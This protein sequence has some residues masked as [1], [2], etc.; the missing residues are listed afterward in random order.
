ML[1]TVMR[2]FTRGIHDPDV[3]RDTLRGLVPADRSLFEVYMVAEESRRSKAEYALLQEEDARAQEFQFYKDVVHRNMPSVQIDSLKASFQANS[4]HWGYQNQSHPQ[5]QPM[6][7]PMAWPTQ[8]PAYPAPAP[9][10]APYYPPQP[11]QHP[12]PT[13]PN[14]YQAPRQAGR[15]GGNHNAGGGN[16]NGGGGNGRS[17]NPY[18]NGTRTFTPGSGVFV[19]IRCGEDGHISRNCINLPLSRNEQHTLR[20]MILGNRDQYPGFPRPAITGTGPLMPATTND[21]LPSRPPTVGVHSMT[22]GMAGLQATSRN[23][24]STEAFLGEGSGPNKRPHVE[25]AIPPIVPLASRPP[26]PPATFQPGTSTN[27]GFFFPGIPVQKENE[28]P[29]KKGQKRTGKAAT[30]APLVGLIDE[31]TG[32]VDKPTSVRQLLKSQKIDMTWMDFCVWSPTVCRELKRL[33]TRMSNRKKKVLGRS[34]VQADQG[35]DMNVISTAMARQLGLTFHSLS[36]VGFAGLTMKTADHRET[37]L[38]HWVYLEL[39]V[40]AIWRQIRCFVAPELQFPVQGLDHLSLLLGIPWL[41]SV[42]AII[43]IRGSKIEI[44]DPLQGEAVREVVGPE[45]VFSQDHNLLMYPKA[46]LT[47]TMDDNSD[48]EDDEVESDTDSSFRWAPHKEWWLRKL[49]QDGMLGG[50]YERTQHAN[51]RLSAWN[52]RAV[53]V[54]KEED[55][56]PTDEPRITFDCSKVKEDMPGSY[57]ELMSK[58]HDYL[59][60]PRHQTFFQADVKHGYFSVVLHPEDLHLFAF[61]IPGIG[62]LQPTQMPQ[63][64]RSAGF[65]MLELMNITLGPIPEPQSEPSLMHGEHAKPAPIAFYMDD[66][67]SGHPDF[68]SQFAFLRDQFFPRI[69]WAKLTLSFRKF[70]LFVDHIKALGVEHHVGGKVHILSKRV[71]TITKWPEPTNAKGLSFDILR[72]KY[73]TNVAMNGIDWSLDVYFYSDASGFAGGLV[74][75]QFQK[76]NGELNPVEVPIIYDALT[77]SVTEQK[78]QTYK[79]EL[80]AIVKFATKFQYLLRNPERPGIIHTDHKPLIH[81]LKSSLHDGI[82]GHW[83]ARLRE[84]HVKIVHIK[85]TRNVIADGLSRTIFFKEDCEEDDTVRMAREHI[86]RDGAQWIWK[87]GK[88][89]FESFLKK[90]ADGE[91]AEVIGNGTLHSIPVF[92]LQSSA[93]WQE[94]YRAS[95]WFGAV[96]DYAS[97]GDLPKP[98]SAGFLGKCLDY[99]VDEDARL[100]IHRG[101]LHLL[102]IPES[103]VASALFEAHD[104]SGHWAKDGTILKLRGLVYWPS[105][106]TD[107]ERYIAGCL[108]CA[109][110]APA[111]RS[112]LLRPVITHRPFQL[113]AMDFVG[114]MKKTIPAG[115]QYILHIMDYFSRYSMTYPS[116]AANALD[117]I[118]ALDD[119]FSRFT[120]PEAF[121]LDRGQHFENQVVEEYMERHGVKLLFGPSWSSKSFGLIERGNRILEDVIRKSAS[122]SSEWDTVLPKATQE[123]NSRVISHLRYSPLNILMGLTPATPFATLLGDS[124]LTE[125]VVPQWIDSI[126]DPQ[127]HSQ[128]VQE[129]LLSLAARRKEVLE[130]NEEEK[131]KM[132]ERYNRGVIQ[133]ELFAGD[134]VLL[135]QKESTKL[136]ARWRGPFVV[137]KPGDHASFHIR[138]ING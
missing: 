16:Y 132:A 90:L 28:R 35:S 68:E 55:P 136:G 14:A 88:D 63:G 67:F 99:R 18:I 109:R 120:R 87:D 25:E 22:Y 106:S 69:E 119:M 130:S 54:D 6:Q 128:A 101:G 92:A 52:A 117:V 77:F 93:S 111:Q 100:W 29:K 50:V 123:I 37:Q 75:T 9:A 31:D 125:V 21:A 20:T 48:N 33:L 30:I 74:I 47:P 105:Q 79:R 133:R 23:V 40:E 49:V 34:Q 4:P 65:T 15:A 3:R 118:R 51:G 102:C 98:T 126:A 122:S 42:N 80:C 73:A 44:G 124:N 41:Y 110:H 64:S 84:L 59:S 24:N 57:L 46:I 36:D 112:Q 95:S 91:K 58:V 10:P 76:V 38:H 71:E 13:A 5:Q 131:A 70:R 72:I 32:F 56:K 129:H 86:Q 127:R 97:T 27:Q 82:Y 135:H 107:V 39:G 66:L 134:L 17:D 89:G 26:V 1:D 83:A 104:N 7:Q 12:I 103:K 60:D 85:G 78:Y 116:A 108:S 121:F 2:A 19:Y 96:Y 11:Q 53:I 8:A 45:L 61:S 62:Q 94:A 43:G 81:F 137:D 138:Q 115:Y 113:L 114:P